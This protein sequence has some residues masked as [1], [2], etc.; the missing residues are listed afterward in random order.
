MKVLVSPA[1]SVLVFSVEKPREF[2][3][4]DGTHHPKGIVKSLGDIEITRQTA[5]ALQRAKDAVAAAE[6][7]ARKAAPDAPGVLIPFDTGGP[8]RHYDRRAILRN[9]KYI[10]Q[11]LADV[12]EGT[13]VGLNTNGRGTAL[14]IP[15]AALKDRTE[16]LK[17][18][19]QIAVGPEVTPRQF[20]NAR[21]V[22][23][24]IKGQRVMVEFDAADID[25]VNRATGKNFAQTVSMV[26][27]VL[28]VIA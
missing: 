12:P 7:E 3:A 9:L 16:G 4:C 2:L 27:T 18:G 10:T 5:A 6:R 8:F 19:S 11:S 14:D 15:R 1:G 21:G 24:S 23:K 17:T 28:E 22:V 25:R 26:R 13:E 20:I